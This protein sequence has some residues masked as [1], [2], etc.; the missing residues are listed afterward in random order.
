LRI[1]CEFIVNGLRVGRHCA[2][3]FR[4]S[5][6]KSQIVR[7]ARVSRPERT[8]VEMQFF[9]LDQLLEAD[10]RARLIWAYVESLD[11]EP[12]YA[13]IRVSDS[14]AGR[15]AIAPE[16]LL[17]LWLLATTDGYG[18]AREL[19]RLTE[20]HIAYRWMCGGVSV[21]YHTLSDFR[22]QNG[23]AL[24][25]ILIDSVASLIKQELI[26]LDTIAQDG[27]R[28]RANAGK[29]SFRRKPTLEQ[30]QQQAE[31]HLEKIKQESNSESERIAGEAKRKAARQ[32][33]AE[34]RAQRIE[35]ALKQ[36]NELSQRREKRAKGSGDETRISTTDPDARNMK[37][38]NGGFSPALNV[39]FSTDADT[40][41]IVAVEVSNEGTD[42]GELAP[43]QEEVIKNYGKTPEHVLVD[44]AYA[45]K[46]G[47]TAVEE[48]GTKVVSTV[49]RT[50]QLA[51]HGKDAHERQK[52]DTDQYANFRARMKDAD[53]KKMY[54]LRP[55]IAEYPNA[56]CRNR[57]L[58]QF[59][60]RGMVKAKAVVLLHVLAYNLT[61]M[62]NLGF[63]RPNR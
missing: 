52:G 20:E 19:A 49:P 45:T 28:V 55:S 51:K 25:K 50:E 40:R 42:G 58:Q 7:Q 15:S 22:S 27:M 43:M 59:N 16:V 44:S 4:M 29:G 18:S 1:G 21:N 46:E 47:V 2:R 17:A 48:N 54:K 9:A 56:V 14:L 60:V 10:H 53:Y 5:K 62:L 24:E 12:F 41:I 8:Q 39:Q 38:A 37:M 31:A 63:T 30:L 36:H 3:K 34:D 61:R 11:L 13:K 23:Q 6:Q 32:R 26:P 57:G 33:A 35:E